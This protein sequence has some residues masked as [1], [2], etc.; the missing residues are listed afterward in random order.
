MCGVLG[1]RVRACTQE[2]SG[3]R[4]VRAR[5][6]LCRL[7][8]ARSTFFPERYQ[9]CLVLSINPIHC[10]NEFRNSVLFCC[11]VWWAVDRAHKSA[12]RLSPPQP[13]PR[14]RPSLYTEAPEVQGSSS[15][16]LVVLDLPAR[17]RSSSFLPTAP[18][19]F[20]LH[21]DASVG[22]M[23]TLSITLLRLDCR[24]S[25]GRQQRKVRLRQT[26]KTRANL[27]FLHAD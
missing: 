4:R 1:G 12:P 22:N 15:G 21:P 9:S 19:Y 10:G 11:V 23:Q 5:A 3:G 25:K 8:L 20:I 16:P 24:R 26:T 13:A 17:L 6:R 14:P 18:P 2:Q 7:A 27:A